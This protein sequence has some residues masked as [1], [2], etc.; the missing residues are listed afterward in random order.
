M[1]FNKNDRYRNEYSTLT[2][3]DMT[4]YGYDDNKTNFI[5]ESELKNILDDIESRIKDIDDLLEPIEGLEE[6]NEIKI[7][8]QELVDMIY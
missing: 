5:D 2:Y 8:V 6:I 7:K 4:D 3:S 1:N